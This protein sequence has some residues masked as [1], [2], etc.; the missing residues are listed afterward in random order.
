MDEE[1]EKAAFEMRRTDHSPKRPM[2]ELYDL[3]RIAGEIKGEG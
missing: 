2:I 3:K 1:L